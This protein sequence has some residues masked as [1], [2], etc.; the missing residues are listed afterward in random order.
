MKG[1]YGVREV[2]KDS[3]EKKDEVFILKWIF[4]VYKSIRL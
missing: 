3:V 1:R 2:S 4:F